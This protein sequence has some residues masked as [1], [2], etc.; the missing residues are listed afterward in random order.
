MASIVVENDISSG[1]MEIKREIL[2]LKDPNLPMEHSFAFM[3]SSISRGASS[4]ESDIMESSIFRDVFPQT[5]LFGFFGNGVIG[6]NYP[7]IIAGSRRQPY[8]ETSV[9]VFLLVYVTSG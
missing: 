9:T 2:K 3:F 7:E 8:F 4:H 6:M 5:P 1:E